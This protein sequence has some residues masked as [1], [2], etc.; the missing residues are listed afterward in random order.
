[1]GDA[2]I[3]MANA[4]ASSSKK[5]GLTTVQL[6]DPD[7][8][9]DDPVVFDWQNRGS[10]FSAFGG[11]D[12]IWEALRV[13]LRNGL[14]TQGTSADSE[15]RIAH[16]GSNARIVRPPKTYWDMIWEGL[17]DFTL[18]I[19]IIAAVVGTTLGII[20]EG[21]ANGWHEG[22]AI[23]FAVVLV[24]N[25]T[26]VNDLQSQAQFRALQDKNAERYV[27]VIRD[28]N[29]SG[30]QLFVG[31][32]L[33]GDLVIMA[34]GT[35]APADGIMVGSQGDVEMDE[36]AMTGESD[37]VKK[38]IDKDPFIISGSTC[39]K[40]ELTMVVIGVGKASV[41]GRAAAL[42][43]T[44]VEPTPLQK[45]LES[46]A[47]QV[48]KLGALVGAICFFA[49]LIK[50]MVAY[51]EGYGTVGEDG[52]K[53]WTTENW[54]KL[55]DFLIVAVTVL[56]VAIPEGLPLAVTISLAYS[57]KQMQKDNILVR[58]LS[59]CE[60]MGGATTI[61]TDKTGTLTLNQMTVMQCWTET[62]GRAPPRFHNPDDDK[63]EEFVTSLNG[64]PPHHKQLLI[65]NAIFNSGNDTDILVDGDGK[66]SVVGSKT[67]GALLLL[68]RDLGTDYKARRQGGVVEEKFPFHSMRKRSSVLMTLGGDGNVVVEGEGA[69]SEET[70]SGG[71]NYRLFVKGASE[72]VLRLC[73]HA[74]DGSGNPIP[75]NGNFQI[76]GTG[77][78]TGEGRKA[79]IA[80]DVINAM[81]GKALRTIAL[82]YRDFDSSVIPHKKSTV[83]Y[84]ESEAK[85]SGDCPAVED[86]LT[87]IGIVGIQ[88]PV[89]PEVPGAVKDC[90]S[91][92]IV[93]RMV[94]GDN[95]TTAMAIARQCD[96]YHPDKG[97]IAVE[98]PD[99][100]KRVAQDETY[101]DTV[102]SK[103]EVM[104][105]SA[106]DDKHLMVSRLM[107]KGN[108]VAVTG[109]GA[110]DGPALKKA[111]VG[112]AMGIAGTDVAKA[113]SDI[114]LMDDNFVSVVQAVMWGRNVYDA[115]RKFLQFQLTV[116]L[117]ALLVAFLGAVSL[118]ES[119][120]KATQMLWVNLIMDTF[121]ALALATEP[122][123]RELLNRRPYGKDESLIS[124]P[125]LRNII[126]QFF[127]Q[128]TIIIGLVYWG[129]TI[130]EVPI[131]RELFDRSIQ[132]T[133]VFQTF[134]MLQLFNEVS[135]RKVCDELNIF[136]GL[137]NNPLFVGIMVL[138]FVVQ[139][140]LVEGGGTFVSVMPLSAAEH[141]VCIILGAVG[142][143]VVYL[144][145]LLPKEI[146]ADIFAGNAHPELTEEERQRYGSFTRRNSHAANAAKKNAEELSESQKR[147]R[148]E[149]SKRGGEQAIVKSGDAAAS[150][151]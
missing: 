72:M 87:L 141:G 89:R 118:N 23:L 84:T 33:V 27:K 45:K 126:G 10:D 13:D 129:E 121:A 49:M 24:L 146:I 3:E 119:P 93:V 131:G 69:S 97:G 53:E 43:D 73:T 111:N 136:D 6:S 15:D 148:V 128:A 41:A 92:G 57:Q 76:S 39:S 134:V 86:N 9:K 85:G 28:G 65:D 56:V 127:F 83:T 5:F 50:H 143:A 100:R 123:T 88:D 81:A 60:T 109:D 105:R 94:T 38:T 135:S 67:E 107:E 116:N 91:A 114:I 151:L 124:Q 149:A 35:Q 29:V 78:V 14:T 51:N 18:I 4:G 110:N 62:D 44:E 12:A 75:L 77:E 40:G 138:T 115:I 26:A 7:S 150:T 48:S 98:G 55:V 117:V 59:A 113:A 22:A 21:A 66:Q 1:M 80:R 61:C 68:S 137:F 139:Y 58:N 31:D 17:H 103:I 99:F 145:K 36:S 90:Q 95:I 133:V 132:Y 19:L 16:F 25:V 147:L 102:G 112:F 42:L 11:L 32:L 101:F 74:I 106:P 144:I 142:L 2:D 8:K 54:A 79:E 46:L 30:E 64:L 70:K 47:L 71:R 130:L 120:L 108:V 140:L 125:M 37:M 34:Q 82:A 52:E 63:R 96:L 104:A 122:P 20:T